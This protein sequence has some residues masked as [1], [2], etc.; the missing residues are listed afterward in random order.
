MT[1]PNSMRGNLPVYLLLQFQDLNAWFPLTRIW[2]GGIFLAL[3]QFF[4]NPEKKTYFQEK[5]AQKSQRIG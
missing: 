5:M 1:H 4:E 3:R 2:M